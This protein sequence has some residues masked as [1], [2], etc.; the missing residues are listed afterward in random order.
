M[1]W[2]QPAFFWGLFGISVPLAI[3]LWNGR[4]GKVIAW[5]AT[6]W[7][8]PVE[9]Q[10]SRSLKLDQ[11]LL[12]L[13]RIALWA[14]LVLL[15]V[16]LWW[17]SFGKN[18]APTVIHLVIPKAYVEADFRFELEQALERGEE[19]V[20]LA[21][22][23]PEYETGQNPPKGFDPKELQ[24]YLEMLPKDQ[25]SIH[26]YGT[27]SK[28]EISQSILWVPKIPQVHLASK[29]SEQ[30]VSGQAIQL[31]SGKFLRLDEQGMLVSVED[32]AGISKEKIAFSGVIPVYFE[33]KDEVKKGDIDAALKALTQVYGLSFS[34]GEKS[35]AKVIFSDQ[36]AETPS[37][38]KLYF[39][40]ESIVN[41]ISDVQV[42]LAN[43]VSM[44]W[45][46]L[47]D[48]GILAELIL[49][50]LLHFL[51]ISDR[52]V[53]LT[54]SQI[55]QRFVEI[56]KPQQSAASNTS[57]IFLMLIVLLFGLERFLANRSNL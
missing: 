21:E 10:S 27:G 40:T 57:K 47:V 16:G 46:E 7:L 33:L 56:P 50:P 51:G 28:S 25:D 31:E 1:E 15:F 14:M 17:K 45:G 54:K 53:F 49:D 55:E 9:S 3:H 43:S 23:L 29:L 42:S 12:L 30:A 22:G 44:P 37:D 13:V 24:V 39:Q 18:D 35:N 36:S 8:S 41:S 38:G 11:L 20:W 34:E 52:E 2:I 32:G 48:K 6:A 19:V 4:R 26:W 5:A